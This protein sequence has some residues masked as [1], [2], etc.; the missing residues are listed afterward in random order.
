VNCCSSISAFAD[1]FPEK[2]IEFKEIIIPLIDIMK[3]KTDITRKNAAVCLAKL[4]KDEENAD[5][6][7]QNHGTEILVSL[8]S[9]LTK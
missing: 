1:V 5:F 3:E 9:V 6:M 2:L 4:C 7:R 8:G